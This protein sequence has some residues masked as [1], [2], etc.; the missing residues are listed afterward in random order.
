MTDFLDTVIG[1][2]EAERRAINED[3]EARDNRGSLAFVLAV[4]S[5]ASDAKEALER[6]NAPAPLDE[7]A[8]QIIVTALG[9][10]LEA[11]G[12]TVTRRQDA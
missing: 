2:I 12:Y 7:Y 10:G 8:E 6:C 11:F 9:V 3:F 1:H 5:M 4:C